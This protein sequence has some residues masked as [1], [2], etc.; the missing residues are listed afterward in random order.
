MVKSMT[1]RKFN[2]T[3]FSPKVEKRTSPIH[4]RGLFSKAAIKKG[5][6]IVVKGGYVFAKNQRDEIARDRTI[7]NSN[8]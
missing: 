2:L 7:R 3:Y 8:H 4:G 1:D 6:I 5:E